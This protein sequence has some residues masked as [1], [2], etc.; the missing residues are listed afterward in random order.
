MPD[1]E[2]LKVCGCYCYASTLKAHRTKFDPRARKCIFLG[3]KPGVKGIILFD[4]NNKELFL[5]RDV[6]FHEHILPYTNSQAFSKMEYK[7]RTR[8]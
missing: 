3:S 1:L 2:S 8:K 7:Q 4:L 5:S 6:I